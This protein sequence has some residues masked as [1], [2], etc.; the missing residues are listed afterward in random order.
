MHQSKTSMHQFSEPLHQFDT[1]MHQPVAWMH[2]CNLLLHQHIAPKHK[3]KSF[4]QQ[5]KITCNKLKKSGKKLYF[6]YSRAASV[7]TLH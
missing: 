3:C 2:P 5:C 1:L 4:M 6:S 7:F